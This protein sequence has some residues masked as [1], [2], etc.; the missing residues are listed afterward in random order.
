M[1][2]GTWAIESLRGVVA[3]CAAAA[4]LSESDGP[5]EA[6]LA[7]APE[8]A[9]LVW[10]DTDT[11]AEP[12]AES[13]LA[14][15]RSRNDL[16]LLQYTS[17]S[18]GAPKGVMVTHSALLAN[19]ESQRRVGVGPSDVFVE[20]LPLFHDLGLIAGVLNALNAG[21]RTILIA[22]ESF[23]MRPLRWLAAITRYRGTIAHSPD[24]GYRHCVER[25]AAAQRNDLDL[26]SW[27]VAA[28]GAEPIRAHTLDRFNAAFAPCG[29]DPQAWL[30][31]YG[32]AECT[33]MVSVPARRR[34]GATR[35]ILDAEALRQG[36]VV[37][38]GTHELVSS[39]FPEATQ[40]RVEI[41]D[42]RARTRAAAGQVGE[43]WIAGP[44]VCAGYWA[45]PERSR[46]TFEATMAE[47]P[48]TR[49][50]RTGDLGFLADGELYVTG[51][52]KE[53]I[54]VAGRNHHP[55]DIETTVAAAH[56]ALSERYCAAFPVEAEDGERLVVVVGL[57]D[58]AANAEELGRL[59]RNAVSQRHGIA[60]TELVIVPRRMITRTTS[61][62]P[63]RAAL[64]AAYL[65]GE[66][67]RVDSQ[68]GMGL[69]QPL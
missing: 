49:F 56:A 57:R 29:F 34:A 43:I 11:D 22:P 51:R 62:K 69:A 44:S 65:A 9:A 26:S 17:G 8:L 13:T 42:P 12:P 4:I 54:V 36:V 66:L 33:V 47:E 64:R 1:P 58:H 37:T 60:V 24:F 14:A 63:R 7:A 46:E 30:P 45:A 6:I 20:W 59:V 35:L 21:A 3:D 18:T 25:I 28:N 40:S 23:V 27:E 50:L 16:A 68:D 53:I 67:R 31:G 10:L 19:L 39:G 2:E 48:D 61:G 52:L 15:R 38:D 32:L 41:V 5:R 55:H